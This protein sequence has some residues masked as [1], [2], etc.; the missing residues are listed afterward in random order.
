MAAHNQTNVMVYASALTK[1][2]IGRG[3][4]LDEGGAV[5]N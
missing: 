5:L 3:K 4:T 1:D 2:C